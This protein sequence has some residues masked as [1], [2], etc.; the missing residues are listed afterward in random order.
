MQLIPFVNLF[1]VSFFKFTIEYSSTTSSRLSSSTA[2]ESSALGTSVSSQLAGSVT[3]TNLSH[4]ET[5]V[6]GAL[7]SSTTIESNRARV[8]LTSGEGGKPVFIKALEGCSVERK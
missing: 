7:T 1:C 4:E 2:Y 8:A 3:S 5:R 6:N